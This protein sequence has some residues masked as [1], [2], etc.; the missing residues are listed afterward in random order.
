LAFIRGAQFVAIFGSLLF[1]IVAL[2]LDQFLVASLMALLA[3]VVAA[4][5]WVRI[6]RAH[7]SFGLNVIALGG[8]VIFCYLLLRSAA[9]RTRGVSWKGR[10]YAA[11]HTG[12]IKRESLPNTPVGRLV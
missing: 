2:L 4:S 10:R 3:L 7:F 6:R 1:G 11:P 9:M 5:A 8:L 12:T